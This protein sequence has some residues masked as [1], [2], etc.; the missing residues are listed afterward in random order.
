MSSNMR[1]F[2]RARCANG[3]KSAASVAFVAALAVGCLTGEARAAV[4]TVPGYLD[5]SDPTFNRPSSTGSLSGVGTAVYYDVTRFTV[6]V[7]DIVTITMDGTLTDGDGN[8]SLYDGPFNFAAPLFNPFA[9][10]DD[11]GPGFYPAFLGVSLTAG[12]QYTLVTTSYENGVTGAQNITFITNTAT[13][14]VTQFPTVPVIPEPASLGAAAS[15]ATLALARRRRR[16][17]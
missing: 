10:N 17:A 1:R 3:L 11:S 2:S 4:L 12:T 8:A 5:A 9:Y 13:V 15:V 6:D 7:A 16:S 14:T